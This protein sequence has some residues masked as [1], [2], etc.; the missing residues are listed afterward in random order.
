MVTFFGDLYGRCI[1][2]LHLLRVFSEKVGQY[3]DILHGSCLFPLKEVGGWAIL[4]VIE[5]YEKRR[6]FESI[7]AY[8]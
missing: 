4:L 8:V 7:C 5:I 6:R 1:L 2:V 3:H